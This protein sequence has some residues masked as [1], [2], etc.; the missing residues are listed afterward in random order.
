[1]R[2]SE[3]RIV[4]TIRN[5]C[6]THAERVCGG[7]KCAT[8][9]QTGEVSRQGERKD[10]GSGDESAGEIGGALAKRARKAKRDLRRKSR[11]RGRRPRP[12]DWRKGSR[13][14]EEP[15]RSRT[16]ERCRRS[17]TDLITTIVQKTA[18]NEVECE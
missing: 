17:A 2:F 15:R 18:K 5:K 16:P 14:S 11:E 3:L 6:E 10:D 12:K 9:A 7:R 1:M 8:Y 4:K 13:R